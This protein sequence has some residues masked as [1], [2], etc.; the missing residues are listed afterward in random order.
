MRIR[1]AHVA[2]RAGGHP[3]G[4]GSVTLPLGMSSAAPT[5]PWGAEGPSRLLGQAHVLPAVWHGC[6]LERGCSCLAS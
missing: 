6:S 4:G 5:G 1:G 3:G 2:P